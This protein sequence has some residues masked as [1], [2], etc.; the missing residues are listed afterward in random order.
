M[1]KIKIVHICIGI[2][3]MIIAYIIT[4][5]FGSVMR[6]DKEA[7]MPEKMRLEDLQNQLTIEKE[8]NK[9]MLT[10]LVEAQNDLESYRNEANSSGKLS[11][12]VMDELNRLRLLAGT[13]EVEGQGIIVTL[14]D[15]NELDMTGEKFVIVH[16]SDIRMVLSELASAGAEAVSINNQRIVATTAVRCVGSTVMVNDVKVA[17]PFEI[18]A[19]GN[20]ETLEA[21]INIKGG[22]ADYLK[23]W[24]LLI[25]TKKSGNVKIPRY[26][27]VVNMK[28]AQPVIT[29]EASE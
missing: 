17:P 21:A 16:D 2:V 22:A 20:S 3:C 7:V 27:G 5:Q 26:S 28:Y 14:D 1:K 19:I 10:Q 8:K 15:G 4:C 6:N 12:S 18:S 29:K 11:N 9:D 23:G 25:M 24:G 13:T